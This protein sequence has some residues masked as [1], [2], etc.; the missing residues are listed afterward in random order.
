MTELWPV[1]CELKCMT[2]FWVWFVKTTIVFLIVFS[3]CWLAG[4]E[5]TMVTLEATIKMAEPLSAWIPE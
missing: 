5:M 2:F 1:E 3:S 4:M